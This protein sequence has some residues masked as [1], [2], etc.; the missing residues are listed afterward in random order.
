[1]QGSGALLTGYGIFAIFTAMVRTTRRSQEQTDVPLRSR[2]VVW[3]GSSKADISAM[4]KPVKASFGY[5]LRRVQQD[6]LTQDT[7][8]LAQ[9]G[10]GVYELREAFETNAYRLMYVVRLKHAVY[11]LH[12]FMKKSKSGI[13]LPKAD[14]RLIE[15]RLKRA[16][17]IDRE[18]NHEEN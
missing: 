9:L 11:V 13:G 10:P 6:Q 15:A 4:P 2:E 18:L 12:A 14:K 1:M 7:K 5:R 17:E 16:I 3:I 8:A